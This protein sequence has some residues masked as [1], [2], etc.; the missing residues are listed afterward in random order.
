MVLSLSGHST[1]D[2][3]KNLEAVVIQGGRRPLAYGYL[4]RLDRT[5]D[6][7]E[8]E[9]AEIKVAV[10]AEGCVLAGVW[11]EVAMQEAGALESMLASVREARDRQDDPDAVFVPTVE[12]LGETAD[13][14]QMGVLVFRRNL[15]RVVFY[16]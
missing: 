4:A 6:E 15:L 16:K 3:H 12:E 5:V 10:E 1:N 14:Q 8:A 9:K 13:L 2:D 11:V 7:I